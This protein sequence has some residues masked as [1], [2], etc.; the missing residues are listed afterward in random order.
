MDEVTIIVVLPLILGGIFFSFEDKIRFYSGRKI[1][2][3]KRF[4]RTKI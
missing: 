3:A 1:L 2:K 4:I